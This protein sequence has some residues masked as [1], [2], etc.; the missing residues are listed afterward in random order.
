[1]TVAIPGRIPG[2]LM[3]K[4]KKDRFRLGKIVGLLRSRS[5]LIALAFVAGLLLVSGGI[6]RIY[7]YVDTNVAY[8]TMPPKI[9]L[10]NQPP[11]M[12][13]FLA[14]QICAAAQ[15]PGSHSAFNRDVLKETKSLLEN[16]ERTSAWI[17]EIRQL[18]LVYDKKPGDTLVIDAEFRAPIALVQQ[19]DG[20]YLVDGQGVVLPERYTQEQVSKIVFGKDGRMNI[21]VVSGVRSERPAFAG[22]E[23]HGDDLAAALDMVK[24]LHQRLFAEDI[25]KVDV[26]N[27]SGRDDAREAQLVLVTKRN[28]QIR[29]G[30]SVNSTDLAEVPT[31]QKLIYMASL[32]K[33]T[34]RCDGG[35]SWID[36]RFDTVR[37]PASEVKTASSR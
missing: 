32:F 31:R 14:E 36:L 1:M 18:K 11:W 26:S 30:R 10:K 3:P 25:V 19:Q 9:V 33:D 20:F 16:N 8:S 27:F 37:G 34:G 12:S 21:R 4:E 17:R 24:L 22:Q 35:Y 6:Y 13:D 5:A 15:R 2:A 23:W 7:R 28:T 29:W